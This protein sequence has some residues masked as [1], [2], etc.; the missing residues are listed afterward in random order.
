MFPDQN[1][2]DNVFLSGKDC[3]VELVAP[4]NSMN[5][6]RLG[7]FRSFHVLLAQIRTSQLAGRAMYAC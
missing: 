2:K 1:N 7:G 6:S 3:A 4:D 5:N